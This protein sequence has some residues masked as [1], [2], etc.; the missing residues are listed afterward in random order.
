LEA[1]G[2]SPLTLDSGEP[3]IP[4]TEYAYSENRYRTLK[5]SNPKLSAELMEQAQKDVVR[6]WKY[7]KHLAAWSNQP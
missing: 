6:G 7:L 1:E 5:A 4:Y 2:K 3:T